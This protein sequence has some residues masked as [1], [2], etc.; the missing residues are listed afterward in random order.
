MDTLN[1]NSEFTCVPNLC[2]YLPLKIV[3]SCI[4]VTCWQGADSGQFPFLGALLGLFAVLCGRLLL[5]L[6]VC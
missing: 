1:G 6:C 4:T 3:F 5:N 2:N